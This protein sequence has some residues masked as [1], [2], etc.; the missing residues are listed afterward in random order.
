MFISIINPLTLGM[1]FLFHTLL[2]MASIIIILLSLLSYNYG[3]FKATQA[4]NITIPVGSGPVGIAY[5]PTNKS[6]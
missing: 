4:H 6:M 5:N 2:S 3:F 1:V